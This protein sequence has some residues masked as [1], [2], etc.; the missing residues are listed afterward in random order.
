V[1][2]L[3]AA[4]AVSTCREGR[5]GDVASIAFSPDGTQL[6]TAMVAGRSSIGRWDVATGKELARLEGANKFVRL[7][8][9]QFSRDGRRLLTG[10][11]GQGAIIWDLKTASP[12]VTF[13]GH[14]KNRDVTC[15]VYSPDQ[16]RVLTC[17]VDG[18]AILW[19]AAS[20]RR[21][22][23][24]QPLDE[25][26]DW[27]AVTPEGYYNASSKGRK[28]VVW[29]RGDTVISKPAHEQKY[30]SPAKGAEALRGQ[31]AVTAR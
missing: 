29:C 7:S 23:T 14:R 12:L 30:F 13:K 22:V 28:L 25:G 20:G 2:D 11:A 31:P 21:L 8:S 9:P 19:D 6:A 17:S 18:T 26:R 3:A 27:I 10:K 4:K 1:W 24:F 16:Q 15:A 5:R